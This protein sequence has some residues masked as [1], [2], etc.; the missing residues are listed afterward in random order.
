MTIIYAEALKLSQPLSTQ[1]LLY[2]LKVDF[3][4]ISQYNFKTPKEMSCRTGFVARYTPV[5]C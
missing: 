2:G 3:K 5:V 1:I 4:T